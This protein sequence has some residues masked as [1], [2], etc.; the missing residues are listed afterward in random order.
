MRTPKTA[1]AITLLLSVVTL[2][3]LAQTGD[4]LFRS[5]GRFSS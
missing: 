4:E 3:A 1:I 2:M 5:P